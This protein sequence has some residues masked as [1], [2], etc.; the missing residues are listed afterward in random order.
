M[1]KTNMR[2]FIA[3]SV[4][5][6]VVASAMAPAA[7]A[8]VKT[9]SD[10]KDSHWAATEIYSLVEQGIINGYPDGTFRPSVTLNRGQAANLLTSAL[11]LD[12]PTDLSA[13]KDLSTKSVFAEGAA[14]TKAAGIF[15]GKENGT[16]FGAADELTREQM[17]SVLVRAFDLEDTGEEVSFTD[18]ERISPSHRENVK[19]L[20][21]N[22]ITTG[23]ADGS[24][25]PKSAVSR[26]HFVTFLY[27]AMGTEVVKEIE[28]LTALA[29][30]T[31]TEGEKVELPKVVEATYADGSKEDVAVVWE[32]TDFTKPGEYNVEGTVEGTELKAKVKVTVEEAVPAVKTVDAITTTFVEVTFPALEEAWE[33]ATVEVKDGKG[34]VVEV[35]AT[36]LAKGTTTAQ[37]D[38]VKAVDEDALTGVWTVAGVEYSFTAIE[39]FEAITAA[40]QAT[41][42]N[43]VNLLAAFNEAGIKNVNT[44]ILDVY[45][46]ALNSADPEVENLAD[47]QAVINE[48][49]GDQEEAIDEAAV[50]KEVAD[51]TNQVQLLKA[52]QD[53]FDRVNSDWIVSYSANLLGLDEDN[54][55][56]EA[57]AVTVKEIQAEI[58]DANVAQIEDAIADADSSTEQAAVTNLIEKWMAPDDK[59]AEETPKAD[60][61]QQSKTQTAVY[62]VA[63]STTQNS[64]YNNLVALANVDT[65][66]T[67]TEA[68]LNAN[69]K[70]EYKAALDSADSVASV[71]E[72]LT[73]V[74]EAANTAALTSALGDISALDE[75]STTAEIKAA[76]QELADVTSHTEDQ[77]E[78]SKVKDASLADYASALSGQ[79]LA[80]AAAVDT[81]ISGVNSEANEEANVATIESASSS[82]TEV[83]NALT[84]LAAGEEGNG[85][86]TA[87]LNLPSQAKLEVAQFVIDNRDALADELTADLVVADVD[88]ATYENAVIEAAMAE[89]TSKVAEFNAIGDLADATN[90]ETKAALDAYDY[91]PYANLTT[92]QK[93]AVAE[94]LNKLTKVVGETVTPL[95]F[96]DEDAVE[97]LAQANAY[98]DIAIAKVK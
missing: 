60:A 61:I 30:I 85:V 7:S 34:N 82:V 8:D 6:A 69:L 33:D 81:I 36:D 39:Q 10:V 49:N 98:I 4:T 9:F 56:G 20:A 14:A 28:S 79:S 48:V 25:D 70:A 38:F 67:F 43:E 80:T 75:D 37:F 88:G 2:K 53:N 77:F 58:D 86:A 17:A 83:R 16:V 84:E 92:A 54:Y 64:L 52:L 40:A 41:P 90:V 93:V 89:H 15:G 27:R 50:V 95:D 31:V 19:I 11:E 46:D 74:V 73:S 44:D 26:A 23:K 72:V 42:L 32:E 57:A 76:L 3:G 97:T 59:D 62:R 65:E 78:M 96:S 13:F 94:E 87:Y 63:E 1:S 22:G 5:A 47:V 55:A 21:Q 51:A 24:F 18:W 29:D 91:T 12:I 66:D 68:N 45:A 35:Q 71:D